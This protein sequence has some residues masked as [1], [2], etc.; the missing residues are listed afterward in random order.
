M[1]I[2]RYDPNTIFLGGDRTQINDL[3]TSEAIT[4][5]MLVERFN[6]GG[7]IRWRKHSTAGGAAEAAILTQRSMLNEGVD[8]DTPSGD[9]AEVS[10]LHKGAFA[11][12]LIA[13]GQNIAA[14]NRLESAGDGTLRALSTGVAI[15][16]ALENK[17]S[18]TALTRLRAEAI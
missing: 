2:T 4:P 17:P 13:S 8:N 5:G 15:F 18:V 6:N 9:L 10:I 11:W 12:C 1:S 14:G 16:V 3:A 7:V